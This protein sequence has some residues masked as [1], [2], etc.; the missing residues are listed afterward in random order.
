MLHPISLPTEERL[1]EAIDMLLVTARPMDL[2]GFHVARVDPD[3]MDPLCCVGVRVVLVD[4]ADP[5]MAERVCRGIR[6]H[7]L[8]AV[9]LVPLILIEKEVDTLPR[10]IVGMADGVSTV[11]ALASLYPQEFAER[12]AAIQKRLGRLANVAQ[13]QDTNLAFKFLRHAFVRSGRIAPVH[14]ADN[15]R[16]YHYPELDAYLSGADE[17]VF[18]M[19]AFL[20]GQHLLTGEFIDRTYLCGNCHSAFLN[21]RETCP[22]CHSANLCVDDLIHHF[23]CAHVAPFQDYQRRGRLICPKCEHELRQIGVDYDKPSTVHICQSCGHTTQEPETDTLCYHCGTVAVPEHLD[24]L[25]VKA[26][27]LTGLAE[28]AALYGFDNLF[29]SILESELDILPLT[30]FKRF[31]GVEVER[32]KR[33]RVSHTSLAMLLIEDLDRIYMRAGPRAKDIFGEF[34]RIV[35]AALRTS[36][37]ISTFNESLFLI[38]APETSAQG[39][40]EMGARLTERLDELIRNNFDQAPRIV[41]RSH[42]LDGGGNVDAL[43]DSL[44]SQSKP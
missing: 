18:E 2:P 11:A 10:A 26:Y 8:P 7:A 24:H 25:T 38:L 43:I 35:R 21:F 27:T 33:Y 34:G 12:V 39:A 3:K 14:D 15:R 41:F 13:A 4:A 17:N 23:R 20:E 37:V 40:E 30:V 31:L 5:A 28:N 16:G 42:E 6:Q 1:K 9:Y 19:L 44:V 22:H 32:V 29:R 36:D